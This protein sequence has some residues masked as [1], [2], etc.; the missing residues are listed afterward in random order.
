MKLHLFIVILAVVICFSVKGQEIAFS[1]DGILRAQTTLSTGNMLHY[2][3]TH[4]YL[5]GDLEYF[6]S[7]Q[8]S[9][10][11]ESYY[12]LGSMMSNHFFKYNHSSFAGVSYHLLKNN[13]FDPYISIQPGA[14][15]SLAQRGFYNTDENLNSYNTTINPLLSVSL[16]FNYF[17]S[18]YFHLFI[19]TQYINGKYLSN[20]PYP[21]SLDELR[22]SFGLGF[23]LNVKKTKS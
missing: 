13:I 2:K 11:G 6:L 10:K 23:N 18:K 7:E 4:I 8:I 14:A 22:I 9:I 16:G 20:A 17:A 5:S 15:F 12:F 3:V 21:I 1:K 19:N